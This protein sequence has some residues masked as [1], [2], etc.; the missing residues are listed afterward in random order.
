MEQVMQFNCGSSSQLN[1]LSVWNVQCECIDTHLNGIQIK[2]FNEYGDLGVSHPIK[3][4]NKFNWKKFGKNF[5]L[6]RVCFVP[7]ERTISTDTVTIVDA[8]VF[9][10]DWIAHFFFHLLYRWPKKCTISNK[11]FEN[12]NSDNGIPVSMEIVIRWIFSGKFS[13]FAFD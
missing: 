1:Y 4:L 13:L 2:V 10:W 11:S 3:S 8:F 5:S 6:L 7:L 12:S 9:S